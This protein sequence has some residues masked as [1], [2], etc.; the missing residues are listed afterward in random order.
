MRFIFFDR[1]FSCIVFERNVQEKKKRQDERKKVRKILGD[2]APPKM[3]PNTIENTREYDATM[4]ESN[5]TEIEHYEMNDE[6]ASYFK[7]ETTP[8]VLITISQGA[9]LVIIVKK[10][11]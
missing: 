8:K 7:C 5:D 6:L 11:V 9:K 10:A 1:I 2:K 3:I 4:V